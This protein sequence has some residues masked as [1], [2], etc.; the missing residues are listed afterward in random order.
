[1]K[2][3][4]SR[5]YDNLRKRSEAK[6][7]KM[8]GIMVLVMIHERSW[9]HFSDA[10]PG[11]LEC[12]WMCVWREGVWNGQKKAKIKAQRQNI[13]LP[14]NR[15]SSNA[16]IELWRTVV[17]D[18]TS[19]IWCQDGVGLGRWGGGGQRQTNVSTCPD[20]SG[21]WTM[22]LDATDCRV[23]SGLTLAYREGPSD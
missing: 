12:V 22:T 5:G 8:G 18:S 14:G 7:E 20:L 9:M 3:K 15:A 13:W 10:I 21:Q 16:S 1:M 2:T 17:H 23:S 11:I 4:W 6:K 19:Q